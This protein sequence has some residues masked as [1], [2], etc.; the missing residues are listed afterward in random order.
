MKIGAILFLY[1]KGENILVRNYR[2]DVYRSSTEA[3]SNAI[4]VKK[5]TKYFISTK[6]MFI[7]LRFAKEMLMVP[8][9]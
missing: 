9:F 6:R 5:N 4:I 3:F 2:G 7:L 8:L 1:E